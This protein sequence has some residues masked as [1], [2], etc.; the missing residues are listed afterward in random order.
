MGLFSRRPK[1]PLWDYFASVTPEHVSSTLEKQSKTATSGEAFLSHAILAVTSQCTG[2]LLT[3]AA[4]S[5]VIKSAKVHPDVV[6]FEALAF[7][8]Y[9][10]H[11][12]HIPMQKDD[13]DEE[14]AEVI[15]DAYKI[16]LG[17][18]P[19]LISELTG[20]DV[21]DVWRRR[22]LFWFQRPNL[23]DASEALSGLFMSFDAA[24]MPMPTYG[25][26]NLD[27]TLNVETMVAIQ[28]WASTIPEGCANSLKL[29]V[30]EFGLAD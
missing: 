27:L 23:R 21:E 3:G 8:Y 26:T 19:R 30:S 24:Q 12:M 5:K 28:V 14:D 13:Y 16:A 22:Y 15:V 11:E 20:W 4:C 6:A 18:W 1:T 10:I 2:Q 7:S 29:I 25:R 9:A 17:V